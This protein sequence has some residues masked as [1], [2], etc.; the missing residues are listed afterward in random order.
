MWLIVM[1]KRDLGKSITGYLYTSRR[2][3]GTI[4]TSKDNYISFIAVSMKNS[5][6]K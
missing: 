4:F 6:V 3:A 5:F 1:G 2:L